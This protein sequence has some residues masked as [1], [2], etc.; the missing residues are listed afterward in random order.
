MKTIL[1]TPRLRRFLTLIAIVAIGAL[2][3]D[4][5]F[6]QRGRGGGRGGQGRNRNQRERQQYSVVRVGDEIRMIEVEGLEDLAKRTKE[7]Y[8][9]EVAAWTRAKKEASQDRTDFDEK[10][11]SPP[12]FKVLAQRLDRKEAQALRDKW[13]AKLR[14]ANKD[15][16]SVVMVRGEYRV[17]SKSELA[18]LEKKM[19][20][21]YKQAL[22]DHESARKAALADGRDFDLPRPKKVTIDV[23][24]SFPTENE[25]VAFMSEARSSAGSSGRGSRRGGR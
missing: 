23:T 16:Y 6:G 2:F 4:D 9:E 12:T 19:K 17:V 24:K 15:A 22:R 21:E 10:K 8:R 13:T 7:K 14:A 3:V 25:A 11:P 1:E 5:A 18:S 20:D